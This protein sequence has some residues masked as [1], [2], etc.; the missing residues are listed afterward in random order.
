[1][2]AAL[3]KKKKRLFATLADVGALLISLIYVIYVCLLLIF[4][5]G[6]TVLN[7][8]ILLVTVL[9]ISFFFFK[10]FYLNRINANTKIKKY[11]KKTNRYVKYA[12]RFI[13]AVFVVIG[14]VNTHLSSNDIVAVV[15]VIVLVL[16]F[17]ITLA[18]DIVTYFIKRKIREIISEW[19]A[20]EGKEKKEKIDFFIEKILSGL[21][22]SDKFENF[23]EAGLEAKKKAGEIVNKKLNK[24]ENNSSS[25]I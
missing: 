4:N 8:C 23:L 7:Y 1:M 19:N 13:N 3:L 12:M 11:A 5:I 18:F 15:G 14:F 16:T 17:V 24:P 25:E 9:Y 21:D 2:P 20:L 6:Y 22:N 10:I